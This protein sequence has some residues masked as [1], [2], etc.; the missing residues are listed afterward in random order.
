MR[1]KSIGEG[2]VELRLEEVFWRRRSGSCDVLRS[3][4][5]QSTGSPSLGPIC[6]HDR[7]GWR[8]TWLR[9]SRRTESLIPAYFSVESQYTCLHLNLKELWLWLRLCCTVWFLVLIPHQQGPCFGSAHCGEMV[10]ISPA[11][12]IGLCPFLFYLWWVFIPFPVAVTKYS[13]SIN[14]MDIVC[15]TWSLR[16]NQF[17]MAGKFR[18]HVLLEAGSHINFAVRKQRAMNTS[19]LSAR[20]L[21]L[22]N[23][24]MVPPTWVGLLV[25][26]HVCIQESSPQACPKAHLPSDVRSL[27]VDSWP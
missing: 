1:H 18:K 22:Y 13:V 6:T 2:K 16:H 8:Q 4:L 15:F 26:V 23:P 27:E 19:F 21:H 24:R 17:I 7:R 10:G 14:S 5:C 12:G 25:S 11:L 20:F 9:M 3:P